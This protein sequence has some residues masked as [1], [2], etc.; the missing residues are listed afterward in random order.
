[1]AL[2]SY[3]M[4]KL[5]KFK[6]FP[7][8]IRNDCGGRAILFSTPAVQH[9]SYRAIHFDREICRELADVIM[10]DDILGT[11]RVWMMLKGLAPEGNEHL[12][13]LL[14]AEML[15]AISMNDEL[16]I[17]AGS[18]L[19]EWFILGFAETQ[20]HRG[21]G[22]ARQ[23]KHALVDFPIL[24]YITNITGADAERFCR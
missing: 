20:Q 8:Q 1:M 24:D 4:G 22:V 7:F 3:L 12:V 6:R 13:K 16:T 23:L 9:S 14:C 11:I 5:S 21:K 2:L 17:K 10:L 19:L 15:V 18:T